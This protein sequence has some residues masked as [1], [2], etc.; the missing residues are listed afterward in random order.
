[1][2]IDSF[3]ISPAKLEKAQVGSLFLVEIKKAYY[4]LSV[5][6]GFDNYGVPFVYEC[7]AING[8][9]PLDAVNETYLQELKEPILKYTFSNAMWSCNLYSANAKGQRFF[10]LNLGTVDKDFVWQWYLKNKLQNPKIIDLNEFS[11]T[12]SPVLKK[13]LVPYTVYMRK[14]AKFFQFFIYLGYKAD[15]YYFYML[16]PLAVERLQKGTTTL[17]DY[18]IMTRKAKPNWYRF[19]DVKEYLQVEDVA[20]YEFLSQLAKEKGKC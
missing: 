10:D 19:E 2:K 1:M 14:E 4:A 7:G 15:G 6:V 20:K 11:F 13:D 3:K 5:V 12:A 9:I 17:D 8:N 16:Y 18:A